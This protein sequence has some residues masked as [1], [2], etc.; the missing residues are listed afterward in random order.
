MHLHPAGIDYKK[1]HK[2]HIPSA[3]LPS[4]FEGQLSSALE[5]HKNHCKTFAKLREY[6]V[7]D[8]KEAESGK[9]TA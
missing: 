7:A 4:D 1:F 2:D 8:E 5:L 9:S 6:F 3:C